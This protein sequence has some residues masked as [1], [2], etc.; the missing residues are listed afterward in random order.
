MV[1]RRI[2][3]AANSDLVFDQR[4]QRI[5]KSLTEAGYDV[6]LLGRSFEHSPKLSQELFGQNRLNLWF[7]KGKLAYVELNIRLYFSLLNLRYDALCS[8]DLDTLPACW[9][10]KKMKPTLL[11]QDSHEYMEEVP[12]A[13]DRPITKWIWNQIAMQMLPQVDLAYTVSQSLVLEFQKVYNK[14]FGLIRNISVLQDSYESEVSPFGSGYWVFLGAVNRGRGIEE[15][16]DVLPATNRKLVILG[17]GDR[18]DEIK[19]L[20]EERSMEHL[21]IFCGRVKPDEA[22]GIL[23]N[24]WAGI[25]LLTDE[26][27]SY[28]YSLANKF[29]DYVHAGIPQICIKFSEY[30]ILNKQHEVAVLCR[31]STSSLIAATE[32]ISNPEIQ[33]KLRLNTQKAKLSWNWQ[34]ES[35]TL[36]N[37]YKNLFSRVR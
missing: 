30:E 27:L 1:K 24:A 22:R 8:V 29:F 13:F 28:R 19:K 18:M 10:V 15:F 14:E 3:I 17:N 7:Q 9:L 12:E 26:G 37:L 11:I 20:V 33:L 4:L 21:V 2:V 36:L 32:L 16:L 34:K 31:L 35:E 25:N 23:A 5:S 6:H